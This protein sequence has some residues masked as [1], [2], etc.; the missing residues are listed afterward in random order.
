MGRVMHNRSLYDEAAA[1]RKMARDFDGKPEG[2]FLL[3]VASAMEELALIRE[4]RQQGMTIN[5]PVS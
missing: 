4:P 2:P 5:L 1:C 3:K